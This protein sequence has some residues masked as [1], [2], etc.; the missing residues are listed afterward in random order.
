MKLFFTTL[1][2]LAV[3]AGYAQQNVY[4]LKN[5]GRYVDKLDSA[6]YMR[7]VK[8][9]D[10]GSTLYN[11]SEYYKNGKAKAIGKSTKIDPPRYMG[12]YTSFFENG[13]R[14]SLYQ[15]TEK[16]RVGNG[17]EFYPNG[18]LYRL[19]KYPDSVKTDNHFAN[20]Y[21]I[22]TNLDSL[23]TSQVAEGQGYYRGFNNK[24]AY[25]DEEGPVEDGRRN[26][27]WKGI[28]KNMKLTFT[29]TYKGGV[30]IS[31][32]A[33][34]SAG[35]RSAYAGNRMTSPKFAG[36]TKAFGSYLGR[37]IIYPDIERKNE[38]YGI[39]ILQF[40]VEKDGS[41]TDVRVQKSVS[42]GLDKE[43]ARVIKR[44]PLWIPGTRF[45]KSVRVTYAVPVNFVLQ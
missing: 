6:D 32:T 35:L 15:Y 41:I 33:I 8:P 28:D 16:G 45:G 11:V 27:T 20:N 36:G 39:V 44:S 7:V 43:A 18:K 25:I 26:G 10:T 29:E 23:G 19:V 13:N 30:L 12:Q 5:G 38:I 22:I 31:G 37:N 3:F 42:S 34:D 9:P 4:F 21:L 17:F 14:E 24:F 40:V 2:T 1:L